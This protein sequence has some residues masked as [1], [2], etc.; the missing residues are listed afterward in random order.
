[1]IF[2]K[3]AVMFNLKVSMPVRPSSWRIEKG[4][5]YH[6]CLFF[7]SSTWGRGRKSHTKE[8]WAGSEQKKTRFRLSTSKVCQISSL[9][10]RQKRLS[11]KRF[12]VVKWAF[13]KISG[14]SDKHAYRLPQIERIILN[15]NKN[16]LAS[17]KIFAGWRSLWRLGSLY[18]SA[19][20][21]LQL[22]QALVVYAK[23]LMESQ[24]NQKQW[25]FIWCLYSETKIKR[26][27]HSN[28]NGITMT[29]DYKLVWNPVMVFPNRRGQIQK[30]R[31][32]SPQL[33]SLSVSPVIFA[34]SFPIPC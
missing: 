20:L 8:S 7:R 26:M 29:T 12:G 21:I 13:P 28:D 3:F 30:G 33:K 31:T 25:W 32:S 10:W 2:I 27:R 16:K 4:L 22:D 1:M 34:F 11:I 19:W 15:S 5:I 18:K 14:D 17:Y 6:W 9:V 24:V 23:S